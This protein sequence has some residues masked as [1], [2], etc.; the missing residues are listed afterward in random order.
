MTEVQGERAARD[1]SVLMEGLAFSPGSP[2]Q[3]LGS[4]SELSPLLR[5]ARLQGSLT[6]KGRVALARSRK[7]PGLGKDRGE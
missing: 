2:S 3:Q 7:P 4:A 5:K 6:H 1:P